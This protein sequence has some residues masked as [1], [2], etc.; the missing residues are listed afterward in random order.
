[1]PPML[2]DAGAT[3]SP[4]SSGFTVIFQ[5]ALVPPPT[6]RYLLNTSADVGQE[7]ARSPVPG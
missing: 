4:G 7:P 2:N 3:R 5:V 6:Q 1:M